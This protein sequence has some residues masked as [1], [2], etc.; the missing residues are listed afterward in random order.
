MRI[1]GHDVPGDACILVG[2]GDDGLVEAAPLDQRIDPSRNLGVR[3]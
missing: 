2:Q 1:V 3:S